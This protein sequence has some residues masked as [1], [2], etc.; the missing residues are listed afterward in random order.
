MH[1]ILAALLALLP[2]S[3]TAAPYQI[4]HMDPPLWWT[5]MHNSRLQLMVHG[6]QIADLEPALAYPGVRIASVS[7][8]ANRNYLFVDLEIAPDA[9]PGKID[10]TFQRGSQNVHYSY[11]LLARAPGSAQRAGFSS[12]DAIYQVMPDRFANGDP[13]NDNAAGMRERAN[14][15]EGGGRH[16]GDFRGMAQHLDYIAGMGFTMLW[17]TPLLESNMP[18]YSYHGYATTD[19]Y[20][21]DPRYG[22]NAEYRDF[23]AAARGKGLGV[24]QDVVLNHIG[25]SHW[26]LQ[27]MPTPDWL[28]YQGKYVPT[29]H[30][31][32]ALQDPYASDEDK[33]NFTDGWFVQSMPDLNQANPYLATYLIQN[34]IWWIEYAGLAGLRV[35]TYGYSNTDFLSRWS[36]ALMAE[37]PHLNLVGE[38]WSTMAPVVAHWQQGKRNFN[39]YESHMPSMMD[40]PLTDAMR[41]SLAAADGDERSLTTLYEALSLDYLYP[42]PGNLVLF[43]GNHD[44]SRIFSEL[45]GDENLFRMAMAFVATAPRIPQFYTGSE[46]LMTSTVKHRDDASY[47]LDFPGGWSGDTVNAFTGQGLTPQQ[48]AAQAYVKR[49]FN[50]RKNATVIHNGKMMH[51]GPEQNTYVYFRYDGTHKVMVAFNKNQT[52]TVLK[53]GRFHEMLDGVSAGTDVM[54]GQRVS[55]AGEVR[56]PACSV[57]IL[58]IQ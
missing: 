30:H 49:L 5:G 50:W 24:I 57:M 56:L 44:M 9:K 2:L 7:R 4:D 3:A 8:V 26:W 31:R 20:R 29:E 47:R 51:Y 28:T 6:Q 34:D 23:V 17:P 46:I 54:T 37:Y 43:E 58:E 45:H 32:V 22:S 36:G 35:D 14:R 38:E 12:K 27:D 16:G 33:R 25:S 39:G 48:L 11:Q 40:F 10:L 52:D 55:L 42:N 15:A 19:H 13:A 18:A 1:K 41:R 53:T 21:I